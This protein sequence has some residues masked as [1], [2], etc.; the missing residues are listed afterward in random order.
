MNP[1]WRR[2]VA[3]NSPAK[4]APERGSAPDAGVQ[5]EESGQIEEPAGEPEARAAA[6]EVEAAAAEE[7]APA[8]DSSSLLVDAEP[9]AGDAEAGV[10][11]PE[12]APDAAAEEDVAREADAADGHDPGEAS[13][14]PA[15]EAATEPARPARP[16]PADED[17]PVPSRR[18]RRRRRRGGRGRGRGRAAQ[19]DGES[20]A[21]KETRAVPAGPPAA[22]P[23]AAGRTAVLLD[24]GAL[25]RSLGE[26]SGLD[27]EGLFA[28]LDGDLGKLVLRRVYADAVDHDLDRA[29]L[30]RD[31][32]EVVDVPSNMEERG[33]S[34]AVRIVVDALE[35]CYTKPGVNT[36]VL[37]AS[38]VQTL[39][40]VAKLQQNGVTVIGLGGADA[41]AQVRGQCD[42]FIDVG[43]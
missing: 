17:K 6:E 12:A 14:S 15:L 34:A 1:W 21:A 39:P 40:L 31:G 37:V 22:S 27:P 13:V 7:S 33:C 23:S 3:E 35:L 42:R 20:S 10:D 26:T 41:N 11:A 5:E 32:V 43:G 16:T 2:P 8:A 29:A 25:K 28:G 18:R 4:A 24:L 38:S 30:H 36:M 19:S 9:A